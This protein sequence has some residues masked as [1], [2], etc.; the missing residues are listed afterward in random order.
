MIVGICVLILSGIIC[1]IAAWSRMRA[2]AVVSRA[3]ERSVESLSPGLVTV[4]GR[5]QGDAPVTSPFLGA[6][7]FH[8][9][10]HAER[11][12]GKDVAKQRWTTLRKASASR[13]FA[14]DDGSGQVRID[15]EGAQFHVPVT[16][17]AHLGA[18]K[19][20]TLTLAPGGNFADPT[21]NHLR[22]VIKG[23]W[24]IFDDQVSVTDAP[25]T[26]EGENPRKWWLPDELEIEGV[27]S[28]SVAEEEPR[29]FRLTETC[30]FEGVE[31]SVTGMCVEVPDPVSGQGTLVIKSGSAGEEL[32]I[33]PQRS[34]AFSNTL[35]KQAVLIGA[36]GIALFVAGGI[37][38]HYRDHFSSIEGESRAPSAFAQSA[39]AA[40]QVARSPG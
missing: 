13:S 36:C 31:Y 20:C 33:S 5:I 23:R 14:L 3:P 40:G 38:W 24:Q 27:G 4:F 29:G 25:E 7:C 16:L 21:E 1:C 12:T 18:E 32:L 35:R 19:G 17:K 39:T 11:L 8:Y 28:L 10:A 30:L 22:R 9:N 2:A 15:P 34:R 37:A 6:P 26:K